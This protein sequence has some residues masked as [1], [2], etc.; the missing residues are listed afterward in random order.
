MKQAGIRDDQELLQLLDATGRSWSDFRREL[1]REAVPTAVLYSEVFKHVTVEEDD[2]ERHY[3]LHQEDYAEEACVRLR[4]IVLQPR[5]EERTREFNQR[6]D[7]VLQRLEGGE[8]FCAVTRDQSEAPSADDCGLLPQ[9]FTRSQ[10]DDKVALVAFRLAVGDVE[11]IQTD[12]GYHVLRLEESKPR[13]LRPLVEVRDQIVD[14]L[15]GER[16]MEEVRRYI[17]RLREAARV[18]VAPE[19]QPLLETPARSSRDASASAREGQ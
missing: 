15:R 2:I 19:Y 3:R 11:P 4:E 8:D 5:P 18:E 6:L 17:D 16:A 1:L 13:R 12:W 7:K 14:A 9:C 10:L